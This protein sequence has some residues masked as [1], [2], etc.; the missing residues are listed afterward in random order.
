MYQATEPPNGATCSTPRCVSAAKVRLLIPLS[1]F[2]ADGQ[3]HGQ[4]PSTFAL[5]YL[6]WPA[7]RDASN[8][9][10]VVDATGDLRS[11]I[12]DY[13]EWSIFAS[14]GGRLYASARLNGSPQGITL[15]AYLVGQLRAQ[16]AATHAT[17]MS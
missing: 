9:H 13:P 4:D 5:C 14:D 10:R 8:G 16:I 11:L 6:H 12:T 2:T 7:L 17:H 3:D 15:D 1:R